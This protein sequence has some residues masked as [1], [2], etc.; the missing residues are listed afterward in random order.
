M[1]TDDWRL[2]FAGGWLGGVASTV[3]GHPFDTIKVRLQLQQSGSV[4]NGNAIGNGN[5]VKNGM[6]KTKPVYY[7]GAWDCF[8]KTVTTEGQEGVRGCY[9][10]LLMTLYRDIPGFMVYFGVYKYLTGVF[11]KQNRKDGR[12][13][14]K[15]GGTGSFVAGGVAGVSLWIVSQP[16]DVIKSRLQADGIDGM[17]KYKNIIDCIRVSIREEGYTVFLKGL[18]VNLVRAFW[19]NAVLFYVEEKFRRWHKSL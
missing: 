7:K 13:D 14:V 10:G 2:E 5:V 3:A 18:K 15:V 9:R 8:I 12:E 6:F 4:T 16:A 11:E 1:T 19:V 17:T